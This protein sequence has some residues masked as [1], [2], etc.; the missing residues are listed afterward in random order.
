MK[1][2][3]IRIPQMGEGLREARLV[4]MLKQPG[5]E[6]KRDEPLY[7]METD[8]AVMPVESPYDGKL[9]EWL[10]KQDE[11]LLIGSEVAVMEVSDDVEEMV[12]HGGADTAPA[13]GAS[14][15]EVASGSGSVGA[16]AASGER[17]RDIPPRTRAYA[18]KQG[19][20]DDQLAGIPASGSKLM[21]EDIDAFMSGG[22][23][24]T[25]GETQAEAGPTRG[26]GYSDTPM[27]QAQR[28]LSSRLV[29]GSQLVV[30]GTESVVVRW[31][32]IE[33]LRK[34]IKDGGGEFQPSTFT[35]FSYA[36][37]K[38]LADFPQFRSTLVGESTIRTYDHVSLGIAVARPGDELVMAVVRDADTLNWREFADAM[39]ARIDEA[40]DGKD[41]VDA[42]VSISLTN[43]QSFGLRDAVAVVVPPAVAT[44]FIG[45]VYNGLDQEASE[46]KLARCSNMGLSFD[47]RL[48]NGVGA[49]QFLNAVREKLQNIRDLIQ[50]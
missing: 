12:I 27:S 34:E 44:L 36:V 18:K 40:R 32:Q 9:V 3:P 17:R 16:P 11:L 37:A 43:M 29:R 10:A 23:A 13:A 28:L 14:T 15:E 31:E 1:R 50:A 46:P 38:T 49:A 41:Q 22:G 30:P 8:K 35:M 7:E 20:T 6:V 5:E 19:L 47:H 4:Q 21:P 48:I 33:S 45:E 39:R 24:A 2:V 25:G 26:D 42:S